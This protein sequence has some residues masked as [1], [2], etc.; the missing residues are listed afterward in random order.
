[1]RGPDWNSLRCFVVIAE[2]GSLTRAATQLALSVG[3]VSRRIDSLE[4]TLGLKLLR[5]GPQGVALTPAGTA[6]L[7]AAKAGAA[8]LHAIE[9]VARTQR[10]P[11]DTPPL[12]ISATEPF[13][14]HV[15]APR[16]QSLLAGAPKIKVALSVSTE[17]VSLQSGETDM[18]VRMAKPES[19]T[20]IGRRLPSIPLGLFCTPAYLKGR[21]PATIDLSAERL[22]WFDDAYG[23][24]P[25][26][27]W[28][29]DRG[30]Q[31]C[32]TMRSSSSTALQQA[33]LADVG[34]AP[35]ADAFAARS[36]LVRIV[37]D[38]LPP[39]RPWLIFHRDQRRRREHRLVRDW[40]VRCCQDVF[41]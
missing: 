37:A 10:D 24:I 33:A 30:L 26:N 13:V 19:E 8:H 14:A 22:L 38:A 35:V 1:M 16:L 28:L 41:G 15:F 4:E 5:R 40:A 2:T 23:E 7:K 12:R 25:E 3:A 9:A 6:I 18:A 27:R 31:S 36:G 11:G 34:I 17:N 29:V 21:D 39:R 32:V 20:I